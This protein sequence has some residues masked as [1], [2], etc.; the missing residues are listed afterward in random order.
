MN[1]HAKW[2]LTP[3]S[4]TLA[5]GGPVQTLVVFRD[6]TIS[7]IDPDRPDPRLERFGFD[8]RPYLTVLEDSRRFA[9]GDRV[10][11][12][13]TGQAWRYEWGA[14]HVPE[15]WGTWAGG[16]EFGLEFDLRDLPDGDVGLSAVVNA[17]VGG[18]RPEV[19]AEVRVNEMPAG[20]WT[21]RA[22]R[23]DASAKLRRLR[24]PP[25]A[26]R[27]GR[28]RIAFVA[29]AAAPKALGQGEDERPLSLGFVRLRLAPADPAV[30]PR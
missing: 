25:G 13:S 4:L 9:L 16:P 10:D 1:L 21:F 20:L 7:P 15:A 23:G 28:N 3:L 8:F 14:W 6:G 24:L 29:A 19:T 11:F 27:R 2:P 30:P 18:P 26:L 17:F 22:D 5:G 12:T